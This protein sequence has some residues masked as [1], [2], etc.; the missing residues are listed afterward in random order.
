MCWDALSEFCSS[1]NSKEEAKRGDFI[2]L[3][4]PILEC[5]LFSMA[6]VLRQCVACK[7]RKEKHLLLRV[8]RLP[9]G[10]VVFDPDQTIQGRGAYVC[11][12]PE[13]VQKAKAKDLLL[14]SFGVPV[15]FQVYLALA[16]EVKKLHSNP[17]QGLLGLAVKARK[18]LLGSDAVH[19]GIQRGKVLLV[20]LRKDMSAKTL[21]KW[22]STLSGKRIPFFVYQGDPPLDT[23]VGKPNCTV[24][25]ITDTRFAEKIRS[26]F[27]SKI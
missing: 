11:P 5:I 20:L 24:V 16:E 15:P 13:C 21:E 2:H 4:H 17:I 18:C 22:K 26:I 14:R 7:T 8:S 10:K 1:K 9:N 6:I 19:F 3:P 23:L 27:E 12:S 25:G